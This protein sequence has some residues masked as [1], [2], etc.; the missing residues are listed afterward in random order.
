MAPRAGDVLR[1]RGLVLEIDGI[2][3]VAV[4]APKENTRADAQRIEIIGSGR[5]DGPGVDH[6]QL[7]PDRGDR[8][9]RRA[10]SGTG[11][12]PG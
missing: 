5:P 7:L 11:T 3:I 2:T 6:L 10:T 9:P 8:P 12:T 1:A 4:L